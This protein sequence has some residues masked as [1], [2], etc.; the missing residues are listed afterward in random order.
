MPATQEERA[1]S[2]AQSV[3]HVTQ[4]VGSVQLH[5]KKPVQL[6]D[7]ATRQ[8]KRRGITSAVSDQITQIGRAH[9]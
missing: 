5:D 8:C 6:T 9:V 3:S 7:S 1:N 2:T 4:P